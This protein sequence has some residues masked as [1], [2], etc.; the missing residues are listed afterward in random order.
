MRAPALRALGFLS[1]RHGTD[2]SRRRWSRT[3]AR[4]RAVARPPR[5]ERRSTGAPRGSASW[6]LRPWRR[7][8]KMETR[9]G[10][11]SPG[12]ARGWSTR[13]RRRMRLQPGLHRGQ[14]QRDPLR[15]HGAR[16]RAGRGGHRVRSDGPLRDLSRR[17]AR[18]AP[19]HLAGGALA[20]LRSVCDR[21]LVLAVEIFDECA[22]SLRARAAPRRTAAGR[23]RRV[24]L[25]RAGPGTPRLRIAARRRAR[26]RAPPVA[27]GGEMFGCAP[28][29]A[30]DR[31]RREGGLAPLELAGAWR[32][33]RARLVWD[34]GRR[35]EPGA[36][37]SRRSAL[38][39]GRVVLELQEA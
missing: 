17:S 16:G 26:A 8:S 20:G 22:R 4:H 19:G 14:R 21:A 9:D 3:S 25:A 11:R 37:G 24:P 32:G 33:E 27:E 5:V 28:L 13:R 39:S 35:R 15:L 18:D 31:W 34:E 30:L 23:G 2:T 7:C 12:S 10:M 6:R 29:A 1:A 36:P 38:T